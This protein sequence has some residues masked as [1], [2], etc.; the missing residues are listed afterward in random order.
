MSKSNTGDAN[1]DKLKDDP[2]RA[3]KVIVTKSTIHR[4]LIFAACTIFGPK[5]IIYLPNSEKG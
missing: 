3:P 1:V 2:R 4:L 5:H